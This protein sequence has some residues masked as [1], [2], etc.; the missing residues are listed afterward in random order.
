M[1]FDI[2]KST[3]LLERKKKVKTERKNKTNIHSHFKAYISI[4]RKWRERVMQEN[5]SSNFYLEL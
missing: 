3:K 4:T 1:Y 2:A 5:A